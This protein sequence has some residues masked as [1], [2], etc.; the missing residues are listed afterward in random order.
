MRVRNSILNI[1]TGLGSQILIT[2]LSFVSRTLFITYLGIEYLGVAGLFTSILAMLALAEAGI[3]SSI[4]YN[5]YKPVAENDRVKINILMSFYNKM[6]LAI[7]LIVFLMGLSI[8]PFIQYF[9]NGTYIEDIHLIYLIF[10]I[11]TVLPYLFRHKHSFLNVNQKSYIITGIFTISSI[12]SIT[13]KIIILH[14]TQNFI[15][16][17]IIESIITVLSSIILALIVNKMYPFLR[18]KSV[19]RIDNETKRNIIKNA[20]AIFIQNLGVFLVFGTDNIII[21]TFVS[22]SAV[23]LYSNYHMIIEIGRNFNLQ[24]FKNIYHSIGN[25]VATETKDKVYFIYKVTFLVNFW[26]CSLLSIFLLIMMEPFINLWLGPQFL[27]GE[28]VLLLLVLIF[29]ERSMRNCIT[30]IKTTSGIF[31]Q[32]RYG[33]LIQ[34]GINLIVS[35][36][37]VRHIGI[38]GVFLGTIMSALVIPFWL[39]PY[40]VYRKVFNMPISSYYSKYFSHLSIAILA[41]SLTKVISIFTLEESIISILITSFICMIVP[42]LIYIFAFYKTDEYQYLFQ[43]VKRMVRGIFKRYT[44][45][46]Y[47]LPMN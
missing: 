31:Q 10:L 13:V 47:K 5:L 32:D 25:L 1:V 4:V 6:Y 2:S 45:R 7:A 23:G 29:Y 12:M 42:N 33:S 3:G 37:L 20:K 21:S 43:I 41:Y 26:F 46:N 22:V 39:I 40:I 18:Q 34:A 30:T 28:G 16:Y 27:L 36:I 11:N 35:V 15:L 8:M 17:L 24:I 38:A 14:Y 19:S 44:F 9:A